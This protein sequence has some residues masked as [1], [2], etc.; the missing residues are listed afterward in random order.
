MSML[1]K[2]F[3]F[4]LVLDLKSIIIIALSFVLVMSLISQCNN[5][6]V[7]KYYDIEAEKEVEMQAQDILKLGQTPSYNEAAELIAVYKEVFHRNAHVFPNAP[8]EDIFAAVCA[9]F[10]SESKDKK[11]NKPG[12]SSLY[13]GGYNGLGVKA[14]SNWKGKVRYVDYW[15]IVNGKRVNY[16]NEVKIRVTEEGVPY[17]KGYSKKT[18][19]YCKKNKSNIYIKNNIKYINVLKKDKNNAF[20]QYDSLEDAIQDWFDFV[21][22]DRYK[23]ARQS[24]SAE[25]IVYHL[26]EG[27][28]ATAAAYK[29][30]INII[31][32]YNFRNIYEKA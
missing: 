25:A 11:L 28:Y 9:I 16:K 31:T 24:K 26:V 6:K 29:M 3:K 32:T 21:S 5:G 17:Y 7:M 14:G 10:M 2:I 27:G 18:I 15:E 23:I 4:S 20:R 12:T 13:I 1:D 8:E 19:E 30:W 22:K